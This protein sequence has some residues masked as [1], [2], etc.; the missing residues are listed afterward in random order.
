[1]SN[2]VKEGDVYKVVKI[3]DRTFELRYGYYNELD[4][5]GKYNEPIPIY[6]D[7]LRTPEYT[8]EGIPIVTAMQDVCGE[9]MGKPKS[10]TCNGCLYFSEGEEHFGLCT[11]RE[12]WKRQEN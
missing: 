10:E 8:Q 11:H 9:Y 6:P 5:N 4:R 2:K 1:M 3:F 12:R 7:F